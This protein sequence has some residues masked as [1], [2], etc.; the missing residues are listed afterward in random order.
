MNYQNSIF[1]P[2]FYVSPILKSVTYKKRRRNSP[3]QKRGSV[4]Q[5]QEPKTVLEAALHGLIQ[6]LCGPLL[7]HMP[8]HFFITCETRA[9][10]VW[11]NGRVG[12]VRSL[13]EKLRGWRL[14]H[15]LHV[16][17]GVLA[18]R[19]GIVLEDFFKSVLNPDKSEAWGTMTLW[20]NCKFTVCSGTI[21]RDF[22]A[23]HS[24]NS[25]T[26]T[27]GQI[28]DWNC[29]FYCGHFPIWG[30][31]EIRV[32]TQLDNCRDEFWGE[33]MWKKEN[34]GRECY[35]E[36]KWSRNKN[37]RSAEVG[38]RPEW[39]YFFQWCDIK[40]RRHSIVTTVILLVSLFIQKNPEVGYCGLKV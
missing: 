31:L 5:I 3:N 21:Y 10:W 26:S 14:G 19:Q 15:H 29:Q 13:L 27:S 38:E 33:N 18:I 1:Q 34:G 30:L 11:N 23:N 35:E 20:G 28:C 9:S 25:G 17:W 37:K 22:G 6:F 24:V 39:F 8:K 16:W 7:H 12:W 2:A 4:K 32:A 40:S 36:E